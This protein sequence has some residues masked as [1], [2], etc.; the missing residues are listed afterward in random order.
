[1]VKI[2]LTGLVAML[3][4]A[5]VLLAL[6]MFWAVI[7]EDEALQAAVR[8]AIGGGFITEE[9]LAEVETL[10]LSRLPENGEDLLL[11]PHLTTLILS[12]GAAQEAPQQP[13]LYD[14]YTL[15]VAG[16]EAQ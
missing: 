8:E 4:V 1:M 7:I 13:G 3:G 15:I 6:Y 5:F 12:Q 11:F 10:R 2:F 14:A 9:S 16:G